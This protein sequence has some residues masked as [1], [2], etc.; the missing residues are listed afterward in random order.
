MASTIRFCISTND[1]PS[2]NRNEAGQDL[3]RPPFRFFGQDGQALTRPVAE[4]ALEES[5]VDP[6]PETEVEAMGLAVSTAR[7]S[8]EA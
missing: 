1:S 8:G 5:F 3:D 2:G 6:D 7:S 4:V